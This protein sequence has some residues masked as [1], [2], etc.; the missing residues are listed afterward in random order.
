M[1]QLLLA[2]EGIKVNQ[3]NGSGH[4]PLDVAV[5][6]LPED[7]PIRGLL[8]SSGAI[9]LKPMAETS[10]EAENT[11][12]K[13]AVDGKGRDKVANPGLSRKPNLA[14]I[15]K[16]KSSQFRALY[17][18]STSY[19]FVETRWSTSTMVAIAVLLTGVLIAVYVQFIAS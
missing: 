6:Y 19:G 2:A 12:T 13:S 9:S 10:F 4:S 11:R 14:Q 7:H 1:V 17:L 8:V 5:A 16:K 15:S 18:G 3:A